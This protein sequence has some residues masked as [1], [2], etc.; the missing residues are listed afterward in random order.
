MNILRATTEA[1]SAVLGGADSISVAA[2]DECYRTPDEA[3]RRLARN[4]QIMLKQEALLSQVADPGAGS[5]YL[6]FI[7][8]FIARESWKVDA[9][10]RSCRR[11][12]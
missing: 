1:M 11:L 5:Y 7:T 6:E 12:S 2:F 10:D 3:S 8:D 4:T 9:E